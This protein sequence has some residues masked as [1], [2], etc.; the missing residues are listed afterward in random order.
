MPQHL[1]NGGGGNGGDG[2][3]G[4]GTGGD[5]NQTA[6]N[7]PWPESLEA[8]AADQEDSRLR[9]VRTAAAD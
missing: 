9:P 5:D 8:A 4:D 3:G 2:T 1:N 7:N 6:R